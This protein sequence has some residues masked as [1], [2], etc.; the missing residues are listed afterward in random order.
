MDANFCPPF[1]FFEGSVILFLHSYRPR[2]EPLFISA[3]VHRSQLRQKVSSRQRLFPV[4]AF[5]PP[6]PNIFFPTPPFRQNF[7]LVSDFSLSKKVLS[8]RN[9][10]RSV[11]TSFF[12]FSL[13]V[14]GSCLK[15]IY[16][17]VLFSFRVDFPAFFSKLGPQLSL[18]SVISPSPLIF[19]NF[20]HW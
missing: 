15:G 13:L 7:C 1:F 20:C 3:R 14:V 2:E 17:F 19:D 10:L 12:T 11:L 8:L 5:F 18:R 16:R 6:F 9:L 4:V